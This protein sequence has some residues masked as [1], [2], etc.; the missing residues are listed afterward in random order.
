MSLSSQPDAKTL[1]IFGIVPLELSV[2][3]RRRWFSP[4]SSIRCRILKRILKLTASRAALPATLGMTPRTRSLAL[5]RQQFRNQQTVWQCYPQSD[6]NVTQLRIHRCPLDR[7]NQL[8]RH[9]S[10]DLI[11]PSDESSQGLR[12]EDNRRLLVLD[13]NL[14][15]LLECC[16]PAGDHL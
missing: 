10:H 4:I 3:G 8:A 15:L 2:P 9:T 13:V 5:S 11:A 6:P 1:D 14:Q 16:D 7:S 12:G